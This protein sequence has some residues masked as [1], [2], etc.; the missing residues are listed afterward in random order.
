M[1][2]HQRWQALASSRTVLGSGISCRPALLLS[3]PIQNSETICCS[4]NRLRQA[5]GLSPLV[6]QRTSS[7]AVRWFFFFFFFFFFRREDGTVSWWLMETL[8]SGWISNRHDERFFSL[9]AM[10]LVRGTNASPAEERSLL[11]E[12]SS[13]ACKIGQHSHTAPRFCFCFF[14]C[15]SREFSVHTRVTAIDVNQASN[16]EQCIGPANCKTRR[17]ILWPSDMPAQVGATRLGCS[18]AWRAISSNHQRW[19][20]RPSRRVL[21]VSH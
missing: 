5:T 14:Q 1:N 16:G 3:T 12:G 9:G 8:S 17:T 2:S 15:L 18:I 20:F 13:L 4:A 21:F 7:P 10:A 19:L 6:T 11:L